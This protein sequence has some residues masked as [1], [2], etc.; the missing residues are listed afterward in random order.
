MIS[1][2]II[3]T[4]LVI[5]LVIFVGRASEL[6]IEK[7]RQRNLRPVLQKNLEQESVNPIHHPS[8][9]RRV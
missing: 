1:V 2:F 4:L 6:I 7:I 8:S 5:L 3:L 9:F